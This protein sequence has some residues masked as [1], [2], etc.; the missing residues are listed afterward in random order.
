MGPHKRKLVRAIHAPYAT[1]LQPLLCPITWCESLQTLL[2]LVSMAKPSLVKGKG[3]I[4]TV[5][6]QLQLCTCHA[7]SPAQGC[8]NHILGTE[9]D[10]DTQMMYKWQCLR[11][12]SQI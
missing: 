6:I 4:Q 12:S 8:G 1:E 5:L 10:C 9:Y 3:L 7:L 2:K 11:Q